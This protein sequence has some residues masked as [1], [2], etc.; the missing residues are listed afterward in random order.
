MFRDVLLAVDFDRTLTA[1]DATIPERNIE[2]IRYFMANGGAFTVNTGRSL[3][4]YRSH[5]DSV[6]VNAPLLLYNGSAAYDKAT[7][8]LVNVCPIDLDPEQLICDLQTKFPQLNIELQGVEAHYMFHKDAGWED[9]CENNDCAWRYG[10][11]AS[12]EQPFLKLTLNGE[13]RD[14]TVISMC[15]GYDW[16]IE[17]MDSAAEYIQQKYGDKVDGFRGCARIHDLHA[18]GCSKIRSARTL[19]QQLG[20]KILVCVGDG[21]NDLNMLYGADYAFCPSD[22][23]IADKFPNVCECGEGAVAQVIYEKIP[24][25]LKI[26]P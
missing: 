8:K 10:D 13:F 3:P 17:M 5:L 15:S 7:G 22:G 4:M 11:I 25:I 6:P 20:R 19:Q 16:E 2:A 1:K 21:E 24:E 12:V 18:K 9:Y 23:V 26:Q 14:N